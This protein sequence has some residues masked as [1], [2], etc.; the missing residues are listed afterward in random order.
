M[1]D[2]LA[3]TIKAALTRLPPRLVFPFAGLPIERGDS[4][5]EETVR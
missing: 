2:R 1:S 4:G 5:F 3:K